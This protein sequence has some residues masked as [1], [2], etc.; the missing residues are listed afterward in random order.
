V[1]TPL[2]IDV[3]VGVAVFAV[4]DVRGFGFAGREL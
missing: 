4:V 3:D 2:V 1:F